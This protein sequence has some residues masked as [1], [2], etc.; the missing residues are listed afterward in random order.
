[1]SQRH[2]D[3]EIMMAIL[4]RCESPWDAFF[5]LA[6]CVEALASWLELDGVE[7]SPERVLQ[8]IAEM[9]EDGRAP[10][11]PPPKRYSQLN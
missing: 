6:S 3:F 5:L 8:H 1:M 10:E 4:E 2:E 9:I 11:E 7:I